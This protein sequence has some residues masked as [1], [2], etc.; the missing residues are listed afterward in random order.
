MNKAAKKLTGALLAG[1]LGASFLQGAARQWTG[2]N[3]S[4]SQEKIL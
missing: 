1:L 4:L 3:L 2:Q